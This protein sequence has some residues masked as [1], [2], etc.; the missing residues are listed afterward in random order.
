MLTHKPRTG[1]MYSSEKSGELKG[2]NDIEMADLEKE[3][4]L[5]QKVE[6]KDKETTGD[7]NWRDTVFTFIF[8]FVGLQA[9]YLT[10]G[11]LQELIM[12]S[13]FKPTPS[14]PSGRFPSATFCVFSNRIIA[15]G[16]AAAL[17]YYKHGTV[18]SSAPLYVLSPCALSNTL[19]S[20]C[21]YAS[22]SYV[23]FPLQ[24]LF[25][26]IKVIPVMIMG[27]VLNKKSYPW[28]QYGEAFVITMGVLVFSQTMGGSKK[29]ADSV[30]MFG[31]ILLVGYV[32]CDSFTSQWQSKVYTDYGK[33][34][35]YHMM[36]GVNLWAILFTISALV[37]SGEIPIVF[38]FLAHNPKALEYNII[39]GIVSTTGQLFI[40][41]TIK[42]F[43]PVALTII[44]TTRQMFSMVLSSILFGHALSLP[45]AGGAIMVFAAVAASIYRQY[46]S[47]KKSPSATATA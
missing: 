44:M 1:I 12:S 45:A 18:Q 3:G 13:E 6:A 23:P 40:Y 4:L 34:D 46:Q 19:S 2:L 17:C 31:V 21:Q 39:T 22:L 7:D 5:T 47:R 35:Q 28:I 42:R 26:S 30:H 14:V 8:C 32:I 11:V 25:K 43:G 38:E 24:T 20:F 27:K 37:V 9:S 33:I 10:W 29:G 36:F 15:I 41:Y 16:V